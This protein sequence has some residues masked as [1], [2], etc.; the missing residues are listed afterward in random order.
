M[1]FIEAVL[2]ANK[3]LFH[4]LH[5]KGLIDKDYQPFEVGAGGDISSGIDLLAEEI[6]VR[7]LSSFGTIFSEE[8]GKFPGTNTTIEIIIDPIDGSDNLLSHLPYFGT[9]VAYK[10]E[11][12]CT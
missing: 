10:K 5:V 8:S 3:E 1:A 6:F 4:A 12:K 2:N 11:G 9:S 7:H